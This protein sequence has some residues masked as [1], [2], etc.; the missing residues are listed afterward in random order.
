MSFIFSFQFG[1]VMY[2]VC[3]VMYI[4]WMTGCASRIINTVAVAFIHSCRNQEMLQNTGV[5]D[6][7]SAINC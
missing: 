2:F 5:V 4:F 6:N 7:R 3:L 1:K